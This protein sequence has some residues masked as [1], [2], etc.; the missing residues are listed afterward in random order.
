VGAEGVTV[1]SFED[2]AEVDRWLTR[3]DRPLVV[4]AK[5][6]TTVVGEWLQEAFRAH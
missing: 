5:V 3:R 4:D 6:S 1:R 2:L